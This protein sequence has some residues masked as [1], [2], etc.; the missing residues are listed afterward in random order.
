MLINKQTR[1]RVNVTLYLDDIDN[2]RLA[3]KFV[4]ETARRTHEV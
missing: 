4:F 2:V 3:W 1:I